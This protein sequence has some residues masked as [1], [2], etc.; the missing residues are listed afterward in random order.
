MEQAAYQG[1]G[2]EFAK[3]RAYVISK[4]LW[5]PIAMLMLSLMILC[6]DIM[7][8][9]V[10]TCERILT[11]YTARLPL[12]HIFTFTINL[13]TLCSVKYSFNRLRCA[14]D[15]AEAVAENPEIL[16]RVQVTRLPVLYLKCRRTP[17]VAKYDGTYQRF[18]EIANREGI[19]Y[20]SEKGEPQKQSF[21]AL[22]DMIGK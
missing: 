13:N 21:H 17:Y 14:L 3:L 1:R 11:Y 22:M 5:N 9:V 12:K 20:Y 18:C 8:K 4:L 16:R 6:T 19:I 7:G 2:G 15:K 10:N